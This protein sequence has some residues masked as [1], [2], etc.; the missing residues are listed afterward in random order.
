MQISTSGNTNFSCLPSTRSK[1][2]IKQDTD[3]ILIMAFK[4][5]LITRMNTKMYKTDIT[6]HKYNRLY[7]ARIN[8]DTVNQYSNCLYNGP[9][10]VHC[11][12]PLS[13]TT[14]LHV[15]VKSKNFCILNPITVVKNI[16]M[17]DFSIGFFNFHNTYK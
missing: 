8:H 10:H 1:N 2:N 15:I 4:Y 5:S 16:I 7:K 6:I 12:H 11:F 17:N 9:S 13:C 3:I 14:S